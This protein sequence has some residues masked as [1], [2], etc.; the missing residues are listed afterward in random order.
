M[1]EALD[2]VLPFVVGDRMLAL[3][4]LA[5]I[6]ILGVRPWIPLPRT[7]PT[8]P[9]VI[10]WR[11]RALALLELGPALELG[12]SELPRDQT[13]ARNLVIQLRD[14]VVVLGAD[15]VLEAL[16]LTTPPRPSHAIELALPRHGEFELGERLVSVIDVADW[17]EQLRRS[18]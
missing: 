8:V 6:E 14:E 7:P 5:V 10:A 18:A 2:V 3:D 15:R 16:R 4:A 9:G 12:G 1:S 13:R 17:V 11:G